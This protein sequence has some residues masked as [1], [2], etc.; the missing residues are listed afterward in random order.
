VGRGR[1]N[2]RIETSQRDA[3]TARPARS[4]QEQAFGDARFFIGRFERRIGAHSG[5]AEGLGTARREGAMST[6]LG[7]LSPVEQRLLVSHIHAAE[8]AG[9]PD[10][11]EIGRRGR[12]VMILAHHRFINSKMLPKHGG[13]VDSEVIRQACRMGINRAVNDYDEKRGG[14]LNYAANWMHHYI[15]EAVQD[16]SGPARFKG[17]SSNLKIRVEKLVKE[18]DN[19]GITSTLALVTDTLNS[20]YPKSQVTPEQVAG[21]YDW[22]I[23]KELRLDAPVYATDGSI[24]MGETIRDASAVGDNPVVRSSA[25]GAVHAAIADLDKPLDR[26]LTEIAWGLNSREDVEQKDMF[27][28]V[29]RDQE[30]NALSAED[31]VIKDRKDIE[32]VRKV[33]QEILDGLFEDGDLSFEPHTPE[34]RELF[35]ITGAP[36]TSG[37]IQYRLGRIKEQLTNHL[38][39]MREDYVYRGPNALEQSEMACEIT[40][41]ALVQLGAVTPKQA[42]SLKGGR[43]SKEGEIKTKSGL[44]RLCEKYSLVDSVTGKMLP[45]DQW[46]AGARPV[47]APVAATEPTESTEQ[48]QALMAEV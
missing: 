1:R 44:R 21:V 18:L 37:T 40:R 38:S 24:K 7:L 3:S 2:C 11:I 5:E 19:Q 25:I 22:V 17:K 20:R 8:T 32:E 31:S 45:E 6:G 33:S 13:R 42:R 26:R 46:P 16:E 43:V 29:Y 35:D 30:G 27:S 48:L 41:T 14:F 28:G 36:P 4:P 23:G 34:A 10:G 47:P 9:T 15:S 39:Y 12:E